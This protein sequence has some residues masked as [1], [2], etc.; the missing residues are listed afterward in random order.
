MVKK[1]VRKATERSTYTDDT[2][3][4]A[5]E[6]ILRGVITQYATHKKYNIPQMTL[7]YH[8]RGLRGV[9]S[10]TLGRGTT[11]SYDEEAKLAECS[12]TM[13]K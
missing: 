6:E 9:K 8:R 5:L 7:S 13:E 11:I 3:K 2:L 10:S 4:R 12:I 1:Y